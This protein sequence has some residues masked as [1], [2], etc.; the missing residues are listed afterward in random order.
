MIFSE[1]QTAEGECVKAL[2]SN[3]FAPIDKSTGKSW[4]VGGT[5]KIEISN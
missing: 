1:V 3:A 4:T 5:Q 2:D